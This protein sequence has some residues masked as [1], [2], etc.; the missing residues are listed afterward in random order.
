MT[1]NPI[2]PPSPPSPESSKDNKT[3]GKK[4]REE[5]QKI[6]KVREIDPDEQ[7]Q[8]KNKQLAS[9]FG[10]QDTPDDLNGI[11]TL[12][13]SP[14]DVNFHA[15]SSQNESI[16]KS[17]SIQSKR[18]TPR[19]SMNSSQLPP[20]SPA[21]VPSPAYSPPPTVQPTAT[22]TPAPTTTSAPLPSSPIFWQSVDT[23]SNTTTSSGQDFSES[24]RTS[25]SRPPPQ[26]NN[27]NNDNSQ[28]NN[29]NEDYEYIYKPEVEIPSGKVP[30]QEAPNAPAKKIFST[31][32]EKE[33][34]LTQEFSDKEKK[35][36]T[37]SSPVLSPEEVLSAKPG[38]QKKAFN[39]VQTSTKPEE[40]LE[41]QPSISTPS[42]STSPNASNGQLGFATS[43]PTKTA[44]PVSPEAP[45]PA[46]QQTG[47]VAAPVVS[48][49]APGASLTQQK[50]EETTSMARP[51]GEK[52]SP[53][54]SLSDTTSGN[55]KQDQHQNN[56]Q[57]AAALVT[58]QFPSD[59]QPIIQAAATQSASYLS[60]DP[61][62]M[63]LFLQM[64]GTIYVMNSKSG[65]STTEVFL[66][67]PVFANSKFFGSTITIEKY[68]TAPNAL[69]IRLSGSID[70]VNS[71]NQNLPSLIAAFEHSKF[72][73]RI[74]TA[75]KIDK[76]DKPV[77]QRKGKG[78][79]NGSSKD[80]QK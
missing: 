13:P 51:V 60:H 36:Q 39:T 74:E 75:Y 11:P 4:F 6:E 68:A 79:G 28:D 23:S 73:V 24:S 63:I 5:L 57:T 40:S 29:D 38:E 56:A 1:I 58:A 62:A 7:S 19:A 54:S 8:K 10:D 9:Q 41:K 46:E 25:S 37:P 55:D 43:T 32:G 26:K 50:T 16:S 2:R 69:N 49:P 70:A 47:A 61:D 3:D 34:T 72:T 80:S 27:Q 67:S 21:P 64:V 31:L 22:Y 14:F 71:F 59:V 44:I 33:K 45:L 15:N 12:L 18:A 20:P 66:D 53:V 42:S 30:G 48:A 52:M 77:L 76:V 78:D 17:S 65:I 35:T